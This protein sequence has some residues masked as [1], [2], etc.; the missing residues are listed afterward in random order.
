MGN[1]RF[2]E[3]DL[4][5][6][7]AFWSPGLC[8]CV[9]VL[10]AKLVY[11]IK[12]YAGCKDTKWKTEMTLILGLLT[13]FQWESLRFVYTQ[14]LYSSLAILEDKFVSLNALSGSEGSDP[15]VM[16]VLYYVPYLIIWSSSKHRWMRCTNWLMKRT[17]V[18]SLVI[19]FLL[20]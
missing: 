12:L 3:A 8:V 4:I 1:L 7:I 10:T 14:K 2:F 20:K 16:V 19:Y 15:C 9:C 5:L 11:G 17:C 18:L 6:P 13:T